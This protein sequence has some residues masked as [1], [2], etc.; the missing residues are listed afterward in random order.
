MVSVDSVELR[1]F[2]LRRRASVNAVSDF[3]IPAIL[4]AIGKGGSLD[5]VKLLL[6]HGAD[7]SI[8]SKFG[9]DSLQKAALSIE[10]QT[11]E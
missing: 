5:T 7:L 11:V 6:K 1:R 8:C 10:P 9:D 4:W 3:G 2:L